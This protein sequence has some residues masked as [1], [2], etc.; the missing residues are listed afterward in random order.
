MQLKD[1]AGML[2]QVQKMQEKMEEVQKD[3]QKRTV[4]ADAGGGMVK[5]VANG[6]QEIVSIE[7]E[8]DLID[9]SDR[10]M[11]QDLIVAAVNKAIAE[12]T[13]MAQEEMSQIT[14]GMMGNMGFPKDF[15]FG[16]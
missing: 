14:G 12:S 11:L 5:A 2:K 10:E 15:N 1:M 9:K 3:L 6:K 4:S 13:K 8:P 16:G 7:I